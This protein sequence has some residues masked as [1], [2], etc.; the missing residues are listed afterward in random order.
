MYEVAEIMGARAAMEY[1]IANNKKQLVIY[2]DY[3]G[4][5]N[6]RLYMWKTNKEGTIAYKAYYDE[7]KTKVSVRFQKGDRPFRETNIDYA[8]KLLQSR[9]WGW[10]D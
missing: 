6:G 2:H 8:D 1:A 5:Q 4:I 3:E 10:R 7:A 9:R